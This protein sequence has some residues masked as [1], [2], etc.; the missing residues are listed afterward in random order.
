M[1]IAVTLS[2]YITRQFTWAVCATL[3]S[4]AL[5]AELFDF[6]EL[7]RRAATRGDIGF[8]LISTISALR[9]PYYALQI[10]PFAVLIGGLVAFWRLTRSSE[11][12][13]ARAAGISAWQFLSAPVA[14]AAMIGVIATAAV[15]PL[16]S[17]MYSRAEAL[18]NI[19]IRQTGGPLSFSGGQL[20]LRQADHTLDPNGVAVIHARHVSMHEGRVETS[21]VNVVRL[22]TDDRPLP[23]ITAHDA[24][25]D[26]GQWVF[27]GARVLTPDAPPP[28][29]TTIRLSTDLTVGRVQESF[30]SPDTLS[31]WALPEFIDL[32]ESAG[33]SATRHRLHFQSLLA[34]PLLCATMALV[35]AGFS[36]RPTRR[37]GTARMVGAGVGA[38]FALFTIS[39]IAEEFGQ[40][41]AL[42]PILAAWAPAV[43]GL[44]LAIALLLHL[45]DG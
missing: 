13:V 44:M 43:S 45:E 30:Q 42:P 15:S 19:Y 39:K 14:A 27:F 11:L 25:L 40:S 6:I 26:N 21:D 36:M 7:M 2:L 38:G 24:V 10:L 5:V 31:V 34:L 8:G 17:L 33:F 35:A 18:D 1:R 4:L 3:V 29:P 16:S 37:G 32:L 41:G 22:G 28:P 20:W 9:I 23:P 12:I